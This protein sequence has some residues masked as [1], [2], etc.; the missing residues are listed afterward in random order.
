MGKAVKKALGPKAR[1]WLNQQLEFSNE[2]R[3]RKRLA[4]VANYAGPN[5]SDWLEMS[6]PGLVS[7]RSSETG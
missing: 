6:I 1:D 5:L 4:D 3:L 7:S 2:P